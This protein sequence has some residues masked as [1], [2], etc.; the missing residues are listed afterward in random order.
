MPSIKSTSNLTEYTFSQ[1]EELNAKI[2]TPLQIA[3]LQNKYALIFKQKGA[4]IVPTDSGLD[5]DFLL[6]MG[7]L[8]GKLSI[9]QEL[10]MDHQG[11]LKQLQ[12]PTFK[13][14]L[15]KNGDVDVQELATRA[16]NQV[17]IEV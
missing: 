10:F 8:E 7:E 13:E 4:S 11:A 14:D 16:A 17:N 15:Q 5:R 12:D 3:W 1:I 9:I 6:L 2:L